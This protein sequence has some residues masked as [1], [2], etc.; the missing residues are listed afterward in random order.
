MTIS[1]PLPPPGL[2][3]LAADVFSL[4]FASFFVPLPH[5][6]SHVSA[7]KTERSVRSGRS[8]R[9]EKAEENDAMPSVFFCCCRL[10]SIQRNTAAADVENKRKGMDQRE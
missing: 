5:Y 8:S 6:C 10:T 9:K 1:S 2:L 3:F 4:P 7:G